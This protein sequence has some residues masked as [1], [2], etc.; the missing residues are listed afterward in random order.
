MR[1]IL[2]FRRG[3]VESFSLLGCYAAIDS[4][5]PTNK[6]QTKATQHPTGAKILSRYYSG[7]LELH[8]NKDLRSLR[9]MESENPHIGVKVGWEDRPIHRSSSTNPSFRD[10][11]FKDTDIAA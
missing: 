9:S 6:V 4:L 8:I 1:D 11:S 5:L 2:G 10:L 3:V 7:I